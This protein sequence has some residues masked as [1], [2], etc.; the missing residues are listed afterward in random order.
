MQLFWE[1]EMGGDVEQAARGHLSDQHPVAVVH[2]LQGLRTQL[3][4]VIEGAVH[5]Q[6]QHLVYRAD[7]VVEAWVVGGCSDGVTLA[8][9]PVQLEPDAQTG[10]VVPSA[11]AQGR[12]VVGQ[13]CGVHGPAGDVVVWVQDQ[14]VGDAQLV[15]AHALGC[16]EHVEE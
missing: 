15:Q 4:Q 13:G 3:S 12:Q 1:I 6:A 2:G 14:V 16:V 8:G 9:Q 11:F 10:G 5:M 7:G